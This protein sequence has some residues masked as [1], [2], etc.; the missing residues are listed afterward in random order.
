ML[1]NESKVNVG[2]RVPYPFDDMSACGMV[3]SDDAML[4]MTIKYYH[5]S[6]HSNERGTDY[7]R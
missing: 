2:E 3:S 4:C 6:L 1:E 5:D 7:L